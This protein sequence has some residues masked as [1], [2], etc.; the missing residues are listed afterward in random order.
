MPVLPALPLLLVLGAIGAVVGA[1]QW[2]RLT[3]AATPGSIVGGLSG[4][5]GGLLLLVPLRFCTFDE[6][7][8]GID[9]ALGVL[10][11]GAG[12]A[13]TIGLAV[14]LARI[15]AA[16]TGRV[17]QVGAKGQGHFAS[18]AWVPLAFLAPTLLVL[19]LFL[20]WPMVETF[21]ISTRVVR[22]GAPRQPF[23]CL[24]NFTRLLDPGVD[25]AAVAATVV[26][27]SLALAV[28][29]VRR[30]GGEAML[31][32]RGRSLAAVVLAVAWSAAMLS[33]AYRPVFITT[34]VLSS[35]TVVVGLVLGLAI[36]ALAFAPVRGRS[37]YRTLLVWPYAISPPIAGILFFVM[38]DPL[39]G[40]VGHLVGVLTPFELPSYRA[41]ATLARAVVVLA[42]VWKTL[43]F[44]ILFYLA[45]LQNVPTDVL[46]ASKLDGASAWQRYRYV[47]IPALAPITFFL[48]VTNVTYAFFEIFGTI[49]YLTA[50][51]PAGATVDAMFA[52]VRAGR[53]QGSFGDGAAQSLLLFAMVLA[54]TL[55]QFRSTGRRVEEGISA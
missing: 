1:R 20:Y 42:S 22:L 38:F 29:L 19:V 50:G 9:I 14:W 12:A 24:D 27:A 18:G 21:R 46:E 37:A 6:G 40:M 25:G 23:V 41:D 11:A 7:R 51:G 16:E 39:A 32:S 33:A 55:W 2:R 47:I 34:V 52:L 35:S 30:S 31:L 10:A 3:Y 13:A 36:A 17:R 8:S 28:L 26:W 4:V 48:V 44:N 43:G 5:A 15:V 54:V 49:S 45:G 53:V